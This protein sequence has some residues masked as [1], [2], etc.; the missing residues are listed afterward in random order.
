M[1][2]KVGEQL[3]LKL[4]QVQDKMIPVCG[5]L[6][7]HHARDW[8]LYVLDVHRLFPPEP[9]VPQLRGPPAALSRRGKCTARLTRVE[10]TAAVCAAVS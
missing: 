1:I 8:R 10:R 4:H 2:H 6:E 3:N 9:P 7:G 5:D